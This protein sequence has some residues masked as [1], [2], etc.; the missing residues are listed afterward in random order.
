MYS[1]RRQD[2]NVANPS[3]Q[4]KKRHGGIAAPVWKLELALQGWGSAITVS[5]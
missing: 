4:A 1:R 3:R 2:I 5:M